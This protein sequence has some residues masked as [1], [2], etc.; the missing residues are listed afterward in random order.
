MAEELT[1]TLPMIHDTANWQLA[2]PSLVNSDHYCEGSM[3][4]VKMSDPA[5]YDALLT[6][7]AY[8]ELIG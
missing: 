1:F 6:P 5:D 8:A 2:D 7:E 3:I 4:K